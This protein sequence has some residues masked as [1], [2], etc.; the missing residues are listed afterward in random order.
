M[1]AINFLLL[2]SPIAIL[3]VHSLAGLR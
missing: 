2:R 1:A 3:R